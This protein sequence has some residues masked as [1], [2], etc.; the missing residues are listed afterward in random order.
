MFGNRYGLVSE[1]KR[2][3][4]VDIRAWWLQG[5]ILENRGSGLC[6]SGRNEVAALIVRHD[7]K[8]LATGRRA[9]CGEQT[10]WFAGDLHR[11][12]EKQAFGDI[13]PAWS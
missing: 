6:R 7:L 1:R 10:S 9:V 5:R 8:R 12:V 2:D 11:R 4:N 13:I 3:L